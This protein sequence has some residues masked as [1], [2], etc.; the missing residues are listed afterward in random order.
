[1][2]IT[3]PGIYTDFPTDAYF[4][5]PCPVPSFTQSTG[6]ILLDRSPR[7]AWLAHPRLNPAWVPREDTKFN[8]GNAA[9]RILIGRGKELAVLEEDD[10]RTKIAKQ[11]RDDAHA[12]GRVAVLLHQYETAIAMADAARRQL[13]AI[14]EC[15][16]AFLDG[17]GE[18]VIAAQDTWSAAP[19]PN[20]VVRPTLWLRSMIDWL[21]SETMLWDYKTT[22]MSAAP[23]AIP[24]RME[25]WDI[26]AATQERILDI[27]KPETAGRRRHMFVCQETDEPYALT[28]SELTE[29]EMTIG[30]AKLTS[31][32]TIW[33]RC[34]AADAWPGYPAE[35]LQPARPG[36]ASA[37]WME[38]LMME[39]TDDRDP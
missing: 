31:A 18:V 35:I 19:P 29:S 15:R 2:K 32:L 30:R 8:I 1:M 22:S 6:K 24:Y 26:Q 25:N 37:R 10:W 3:S 14:P 38:R 28:V 5:D 36:Y 9:H 13:I 23:E 17:A 12:E 33:Q 11:F 34:M 16:H 7:H 27:L 21:E 39:K 20:I 4:R